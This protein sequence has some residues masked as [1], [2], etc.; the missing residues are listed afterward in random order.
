MSDSFDM[1]RTVGHAWDKIPVTAK[2]RPIGGIWFVVRCTRCTSERW[3]VVDGMA[4]VVSRRY[5]YA[6]GYLRS[7]GTGRLTRN[8]A[9]AQLLGRQLAALRRRAS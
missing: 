2:V 9:R 8:Q 7:K 6:E 1:C 5:R 3:D 4:D